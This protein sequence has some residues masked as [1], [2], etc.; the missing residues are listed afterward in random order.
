MTVDLTS[1][2]RDL[3]LKIIE[4]YLSELRHTIAATQVGTSDLHQEEDRIKALQH[5]LSSQT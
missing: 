2:E 3:I 5:K 4:T 1:E